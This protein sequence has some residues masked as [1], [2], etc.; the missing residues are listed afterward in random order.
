MLV[1]G[2]IREVG[3]AKEPSI[4][5]AKRNLARWGIANSG[6]RSMLAQSVSWLKYKQKARSSA[7]FCAASKSKFFSKK[8][9]EGKHALLALQ[10]FCGLHGAFSKASATFRTVGDDEF[11]GW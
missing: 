8:I 1:V 11:I 4:S 3:V 2:K 5:Y 10:P 7:S 9:I 6:W